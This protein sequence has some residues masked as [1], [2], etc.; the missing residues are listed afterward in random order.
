V[1]LGDQRIRVDGEPYF[2]PP[3]VGFF[4]AWGAD[5]T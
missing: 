3:L 2:A 1:V 4:D 5:D